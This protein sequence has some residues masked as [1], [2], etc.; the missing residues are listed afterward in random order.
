MRFKRRADRDRRAEFLT[1]VRTTQSKI[2][3]KPVTL[4]RIKSLERPDEPVH[5]AKAETPRGRGRQAE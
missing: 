2:G 5:E 3:K 4:P 1:Y